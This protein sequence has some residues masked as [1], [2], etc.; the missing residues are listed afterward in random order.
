MQRSSFS[1][2]IVA[3]A[4]AACLASAPRAAAQA[5]ERPAVAESELDAGD[6]ASMRMLVSEE[7]V[8][9]NHLARLARLRSLAERNGHRERLAEIDRLETLETQR[10]QARTLDARTHMSEQALAQ[11]DDFMRRGGVLKMRRMNQASGHGGDRAHRPANQGATDR[12]QLQRQSGATST[13][14][15]GRPKSIGTLGRGRSGSGGR[16]PR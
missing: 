4:V 6:A 3:A 11:A 10:Y 2:G 5:V 7:A 12:P 13:R 16:G 15:S 14:Q 8:H 9:R 1:F